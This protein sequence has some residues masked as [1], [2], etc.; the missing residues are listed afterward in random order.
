MNKLSAVPSSQLSHT[1]VHAWLEEL[2]SDHLHAKRVLSLANATTG[3][4]HAASL[5]INAIGRGL[6]SARGLLDK[7][8]IKQVDRMFSNPKILG[9]EAQRAWVRFVL[10]Q[11]RKVFLNLDWSDFDRDDQTTLLLA[12]QT[13]HG[14][15]TPL[16]WKTVRKSQ[17]KD[18]R[19]D[20]EDALLN[21]LKSLLPEGVDVTIVADRGFGDWKLYDFLSEL[22]FEYIIR[23]RGNIHVTDAKGETKAAKD[24][25]GKHGRMR[26]LRD[27]LVTASENY[28]VS[29]VVCVQDKGM[30][31]AWCIVASD[32]T[33]RGVALKGHYGKRFTIEESLRDIKDDRFGLGL[34]QVRTKS[35]ERRD[36]LIWVCVLAHTLLTL[37]GAAGEAEGLDRMLKSNTSKKRQLSLF[38]QGLRW[39]DLLPNMPEP[40][41]RKLMTRFDQMLRDH[42]IFSEIF[43]VL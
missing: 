1:Q 40:R 2:F 20:H 24:W 22:G 18:Q 35:C 13:G 8:A 4:L 25:V 39:Y 12:V 19:N 26:V 6:A 10:A 15:A 31:D 37:L 7:H 30:K 42:A 33:V 14:R 43:G 21:T 32:P 27:A 11:R 29:T 17:L 5:G 9:T 28:P 41:L 3:V 34:K 36:R 23:F 16:L 38:R